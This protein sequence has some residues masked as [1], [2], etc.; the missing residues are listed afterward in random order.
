M[1]LPFANLLIIFF[2]IISSLVSL[3]TSSSATNTPAASA[4]QAS[5][6][7]GQI[8]FTSNRTGNYEI[9]VMNVHTYRNHNP[10]CFSNRH[11]E[12]NRPHS[13]TC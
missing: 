9:Y 4:T 3:G 2:L 6:A 12:H 13:V 7:T 11:C 5:R 10:N 8:A 1:N